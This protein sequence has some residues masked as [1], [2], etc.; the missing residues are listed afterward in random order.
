[1]GKRIRLLRC[2]D[3]GRSPYLCERRAGNLTAMRCGHHVA[4]S[5]RTKLGSPQISPLDLGS[6]KAKL[7]SY[8][9]PHYRRGDRWCLHG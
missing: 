6:D 3:A 2:Q 8:N 9:G 4:K 1:M 5:M 7:R